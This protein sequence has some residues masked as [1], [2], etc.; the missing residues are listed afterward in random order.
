MLGLHVQVDAGVGGELFFTEADV[1][2]G[3]GVT[4]LFRALSF[5]A[6]IH[7]ILIFII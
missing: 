5:R 1:G 6:P 4:E 7:D 2:L 3:C